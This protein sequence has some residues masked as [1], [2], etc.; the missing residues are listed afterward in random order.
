M[1]LENKKQLKIFIFHTFFLKL[2]EGAFQKKR[3]VNQE[4][5]KHGRGQTGNP[6]ERQ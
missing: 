4:I 3:G 2:M 1:A 5:G 6:K